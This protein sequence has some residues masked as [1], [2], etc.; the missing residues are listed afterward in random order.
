M[1]YCSTRPIIRTGNSTATMR[2]RPGFQKPCDKKFWSIIRSRPIRVSKR[3]PECECGCVEA[4]DGNYDE[5]CAPSISA[6][7]SRCC[8]APGRVAHRP[9]A[10][11]SEQ[12]DPADPAVHRRFPERRAGAAGDARA[13]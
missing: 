1:T 10:K 5:T 8:R 6:P 11:L 7:G 3:M 9:R 4:K 12:A 13:V 2:C